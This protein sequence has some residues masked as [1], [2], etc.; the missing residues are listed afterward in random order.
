MKKA[1]KI[2]SVVLVTMMLVAIAAGCGNNAAN[3]GNSSEAAVTTAAA[4]TAAESTTAAKTEKKINIVFA[5]ASAD[6]PA[7]LPDVVLVAEAFMKNNP[8][9]TFEWQGAEHDEERKKIK[10]MA[11]SN[12]LPDIFWESYNEMPPMAKMGVLTDL[13]P[14]I[15]ADADWKASFNPG[16]L[17][18]MTIDGKIYG[19]PQK[20]DAMGFFY[21]KALFDKYSLKIPETWDEF[22][23]AIATFAK[24]G[25]V[26]M[27]QGT[28]DTWS[29]WGYN[30]FFHRYGYLDIHQ[31][32]LDNQVKF[33]NPEMVKAYGRIKELKDIG[34][35]PKNATTLGYTQALEMFLGGNAAIITTGTWELSKM[36]SSAIAKDI[37]FNWGPT[38]PDG[39]ADQKIGLKEYSTG[40][41]VGAG[42]Q[43]DADKFKAVM[44][45][46][47]FRSIP[48]GTKVVVEQ[49]KTLPATKYTGDVKA[50]GAVFGTMLNAIADP[51]KSG[52]QLAV[53]NESSFA[54]P[55]WNSI[56]GVMNGLMT[57][58]QAAESMDD[59]NASK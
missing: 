55:F 57:P 6:I 15:N 42:I 43:K 28:K 21:N 44:A 30:L 33:N 14:E 56:T 22:K 16:S 10:M 45:F 17:D 40:L 12:S 11:E 18:N 24:N 36:E 34:A 47:K 26:P 2:F 3:S 39:I 4:T 31:K 9:I 35:F 8:G 27:A 48:E 13:T 53:M 25:V 41:W 19:I 29:V 1:V 58:E 32:F 23:T 49:A 52:Y 46:L 59:W 38:F 7:N 51:Y 20:N 37:A 54:Q 5:G 50:V